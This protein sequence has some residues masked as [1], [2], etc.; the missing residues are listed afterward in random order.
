MVAVNQAVLRDPAR[1]AAVEQARRLLSTAPMPSDAIARLAARL[2]RAPMAAI[3]LIDADQEHFAGVHDLPAALAEPGHV[4][5]SQS[6]G[7][8]VVSHGHPVLSGDLSG[9]ESRELREH[10]LATEH[11]MRAF[12]GVPVRDADDQPVGSLTVFDTVPRDWSTEQLDVL[13]EIAELVRAPAGPAGLDAAALLP[14]LLDT[15]SVGVIACDARGRV[16]L[17]NR[18][19]REVLGW[20]ATTPLPEDFAPAVDGILYRADHRPLPLPATPLMRALGGEHVHGADVIA[21]LPGH[22]SRTFAATAQPITAGDGRRLGA[23]SVAHEVTALRRAERFRDCHRR[24]E[25]AL[26]TADSAEAAAPELL[27]AVGTTL[28]WPWAELFLIDEASGDLRSVGHY[29][30]SGTDG[31]ALFGHTPVCGTGVTGRVWETGQPL[32]VPDIAHTDHVPNPV[33]RARIEMCL[34]LGVR[35]VLAVPVRDGGTMLGVLTCYAGAREFHEDLLTVLLDG[36][37]AQVGVYVALRR[38]EQLARQLARTQNDFI[39]LVGHELRTPLTSIT[40]N[41]GVLADEADGLDAEQRHMIATISRNSGVLQQ[42]IDTLLDLAG[43]D[44]GHV[45]LDLEEVDLVELVGAAVSAARS[46]TSPEIDVTAPLRLTIRGDAGRLRQVV[47]GLL[48]NAA[49]YSVPGGRVRVELGV[50]ADAAELVIADTGIGTPDDQRD[51]VFDRFFRGRN[52]RHQGIPGS[53]LGL[54]LARAVVRLHGGDIRL[55][56]NE[57]SGTVVRVRLPLPPS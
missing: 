46:G 35:T 36:V 45:G 38:A 41:A 9:A 22:R 7:K 37:A 26:K 50:S 6:L 57:P 30:G 28:G 24:V 3:A 54:S 43:L 1:L 49:T 32:W 15:L 13:G 23:V 52:V 42:I 53:G 31:A 16:V 12:A 8:Y 2:L 10:R 21:Q 25:K 4:E 18:A 33:E 14:V 56:G 44:S 40:T 20:T 34:R 19:L 55:D 27:E 39:D 51:R 17:A 5:L 47:T 11:G 29:D 48:S